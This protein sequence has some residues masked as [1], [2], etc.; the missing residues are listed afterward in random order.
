MF[1]VR[2]RRQLGFLA[3]FC[4][5]SRSIFFQLLG[6]LIGYLFIKLGFGIGDLLFLLANRLFA[7]GNVAVFLCELLFELLA[8]G[9]DQ[10]RRQRLGEL[11]FGFTVWAG[12]GGF[13]HGSIILGAFE[14]PSR[15]A[16]VISVP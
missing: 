5:N 14:A 15:L 6:N 16:L 1:K 13:A 3:L 8:G 12:D 11:D 9:F 2:C 4:G 7:G 10:R